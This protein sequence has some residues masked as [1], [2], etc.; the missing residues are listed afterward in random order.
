MSDAT[1]IPVD[2]ARLCEIVRSVC[3]SRPVR[4][5]ELFGSAASAGTHSASDI[6]LL[7][8]FEPSAQVGLFDMGAIKD[9]LEARLGQPVDLLSKA[10]V[11]RSANSFRRHSIL[12]APMPIYAR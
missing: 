8:E 10:A 4:R 11:E 9:E 2:L 6:D 1:T 7:I 3:E 5:V 12:A